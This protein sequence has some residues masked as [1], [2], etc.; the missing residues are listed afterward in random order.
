MRSV[1]RDAEEGRCRRPSRSGYQVHLH[2]EIREDQHGAPGPCRPL[3]PDGIVST[4]MHVVCVRCARGARP[5]VRPG[6][7]PARAE[8][9][10]PSFRTIPM[11]CQQARPASCSLVCASYAFRMRS[12]CPAGTSLP[13]AGCA[14]TWL[15]GWVALPEPGDDFITA[16]HCRHL[17][18]GIHQQLSDGPVVE[19][20]TK[21]LPVI[22]PGLPSH[23]V[24]LQVPPGLEG[25]CYPCGLCLA[26]GSHR[27]H[28]ASRSPGAG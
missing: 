10:F 1:G 21:L 26:R 3:R 14:A 7:C 20:Q 16:K 22:G 2:V 23:R 6:E 18:H 24:R 28:P 25:R 17:I 9:G 8:V 4:F 15:D 19:H 11:A 12:A 13:P 5:A 27:P